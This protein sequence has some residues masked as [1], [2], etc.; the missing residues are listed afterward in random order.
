MWK[1][2]N[3]H[4]IVH[5]ANSNPVQDPQ[6]EKIKENDGSAYC[7]LIIHYSFYDK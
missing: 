1:S 5:M 2:Y 7:S 4:F 6:Q 3:S